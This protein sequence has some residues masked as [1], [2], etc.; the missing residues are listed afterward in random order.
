MYQWGARVKN[1]AS[2]CGFSSELTV[3]RDIFVFDMGSGPIEDRLL[4]KDVS[5]IGITYSSILEIATTKEV[6][7]NNKSGWK[8]EECADLKYQK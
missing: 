6:A 4:E 7:M 2:K 5:K 1:L 3:I 8:N